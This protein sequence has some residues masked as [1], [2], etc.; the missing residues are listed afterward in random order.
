MLG[1]NAEVTGEDLE[2]LQ[3]TE[4]VR[5]DCVHKTCFSVDEFRNYNYISILLYYILLKFNCKLGHI[6]TN[7]C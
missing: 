5:I 2:R 6:I 7:S 3:Y 4:Q 1:T